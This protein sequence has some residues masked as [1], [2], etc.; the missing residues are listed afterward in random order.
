MKH[1]VLIVV[2][3]LC[4]YL[5]AFDWSVKNHTNL[6][7]GQD[8]SQESQSLELLWQPQFSAVQD[9]PGE[10]SLQGEYSLTARAVK[11]WDTGSSEARL[12]LDSYRYWLRLSNFQSELRVGLQRLSFGS[13]Q[14]LRPLQWFDRINPL[15]VSEETVGVEAT[16]IRHNWLNNTNLWLWGM[17]A[18][19][20]L[21]GNEFVPGKDQSIEFGGR[22]QVPSSLGESGLSY[23]QRQLDDGTE[24]RFGIDHRLDWALGNWMEASISHFA[25][26]LPLLP[27][28][29]VAATLGAD[30]TLGLGNGVAFTLEQM[31]VAN[32][33]GALDKLHNQGSFTALM[34]TYPLGLLDNLS[35]YTLYDWKSEHSNHAAI[36][37][38][39]WDYWS[40]ELALGLDSGYPQALSH[41]PSIG[42]KINYDI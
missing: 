36:W 38:R 32:A 20:K 14:M 29:S 26:D 11:Q 35:F 17:L 42:L 18:D 7:A 1:V 9:L 40:L 41:S 13:A 10:F 19:D 27:D 6:W 28:Y 25:T 30:Y 31:V 22:L 2:L 16:L 23:H 33:S 39:T 5:Q 12:S 8:F 24:Y 4:C 37:R 15:D 21:K 34:A 3:L